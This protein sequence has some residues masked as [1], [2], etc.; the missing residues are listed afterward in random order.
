MNEIY[1][2][3]C[4]V[5]NLMKA[6]K[7]AIKKGSRPGPDGMSCKNIK[8]AS[9]KF[10]S[11]LRKELIS[12]KYQASEPATE[13]KKYYKN[14]E[15][16]LVYHV[17][18]IRERVVEYAIK[19]VLSSLYEKIFMPFSCAY[20]PG[21]GEKYF[22]GLVQEMMNKGFLWFLSLDVESYS[23]TI[24]NE[25]LLEDLLLFTNDKK[26]ISLVAECLYL[27]KGKQGLFPGH[28]LSPFLSN[29]FLHPVDV[30]LKDKRVIRYADNFFFA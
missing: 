20:R 15:K 1:E 25:L 18:N 17:I 21:K 14:S 16:Q 7:K 9:E 30:Q 4:S 22:Y 8:T 19:E 27:K 29:V 26:L 13:I 24:D 10:I 6:C 3:V 11:E 5:D 23:D 12:G 2:Q 28:V